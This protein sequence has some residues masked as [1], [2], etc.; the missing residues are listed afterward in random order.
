[1]EPI[2]ITLLFVFCIVWLLTFMAIG[3]Y[4]HHVDGPDCAD[5]PVDL[6]AYNDHVSVYRP[7]NNTTAIV[8]GYFVER[9][10]VQPQRHFR[11]AQNQSVTV[12]G[13]SNA[14]Q[15]Q[16]SQGNWDRSKPLR[17]T[18]E[19]RVR[20]YAGAAFPNADVP[21]MSDGTGRAV[22]YTAGVDPAAAYK[23]MARSTCTLAGEWIELDLVRD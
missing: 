15:L 20:V 9:S 23:G 8:P 17:I 1:M 18:T 11:L 3:D 14:S 19:G 16:D 22:L 10:N 12:I 7:D 4:A 21:V 6:Y 13:V 2:T 5:G